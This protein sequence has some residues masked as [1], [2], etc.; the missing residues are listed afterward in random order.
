MG[1]TR[2]LILE[3]LEQ[4]RIARRVPWPEGDSVIMLAEY[5]HKA[6]GAVAC[7]VAADQDEN[8]VE[9]WFDRHNRWGGTIQEF[10]KEFELVASPAMA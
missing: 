3:A 4:A 7:V 9:L 2:Q 8:E 1:T 10:Q 6:S 5:C